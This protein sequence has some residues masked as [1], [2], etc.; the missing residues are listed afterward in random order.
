M[1]ITVILEKISNNIAYVAIALAV[2]VIALIVLQIINLLKIKKMRASYESF[3]AGK[4]GTSLE[5]EVHTRFAQVD[6]LASTSSKHTSQL[7]AI[8]EELL[9]AYE[10]VGIVK[11]DAFNEMGGKLSFALA[12]L[13]KS[14]NG[15]VMNSM[16]SRE[17]CYT[18]V[19]EIIRGK[20]YITLGSE[21]QQALEEAVNH[22][23]VME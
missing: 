17:G 3:M 10:K 22:D 23:K 2:L 19:K 11:Y 15:F 7:A 21:E 18:Y 16:H 1:S 5:D 9:G 4:D 20:S 12:M 8:E 13:D 6:E 14:D